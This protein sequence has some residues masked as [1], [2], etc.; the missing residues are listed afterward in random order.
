[1][2]YFIVVNFFVHL[3]FLRRII[4]KSINQMKKCPSSRIYRLSRCDTSDSHREF[5]FN[6]AISSSRTILFS[7]ANEFTKF[8]DKSF[9]DFH[10]SLAARQTLR[11]HRTLVLLIPTNFD[12]L[13]VKGPTI[14]HA[15][16]ETSS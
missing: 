15:I 11:A 3:L 1:M 16:D 10:V 8:D 14:F 4:N 9:N 2:F 13:T 6:A 7:S 12:K 5:Y